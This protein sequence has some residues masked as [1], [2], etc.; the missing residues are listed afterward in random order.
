MLEFHPLDVDISLL[1]I[2]S[3]FISADLML[4]NIAVRVAPGSSN[5]GVFINLTSGPGEGEKYQVTH[6]VAVVAGLLRGSPY[7][8]I[9]DSV[10]QCPF[11][12]TQ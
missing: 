9:T 7:A 2:S 3:S 1:H 6:P 12:R 4:P 5:K 10:R 11:F 8:T